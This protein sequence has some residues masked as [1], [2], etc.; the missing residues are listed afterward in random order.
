MSDLLSFV[1]ALLVILPLGG[2]CLWAS[3]R[4][5]RRLR[6]AGEI[7]AALLGIILVPLPFNLAFF[8]LLHLLHLH[9][10][11]QYAFTGIVYGGLMGMRA[12]RLQNLE[13][14]RSKPLLGGKP[15]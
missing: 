15:R 10:D 3:Y 6:V 13:R 5:G 14:T 11:A 12:A 4:L 7:S 8:I 1:V 2:S 9:H